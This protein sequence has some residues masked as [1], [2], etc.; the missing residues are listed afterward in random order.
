MRR[1]EIKIATA[2]CLM[3]LSSASARAQILEPTSI[4]LGATSFLDGAPPGPGVYFFQYYQN[5]SAHQF[6]DANGQ[7]VPFPSPNLNISVAI[8]Q[9]V[10]LFDHDL[11]LL[12]AKPALDLLVPT[13]WT[14]LDYGAP[15]PFP[16]SN[17][18]GLSDIT[19]GPALQFD[20]IKNAD[21]RTIFV[22]RIEAQFIVPTGKYSNQRDVNPGDGYFTFDPYWAGTLFL[23][24]KWEVSYRAHYLWN[25]R[26]DD[27][28]ARLNA[29]SALVGEAF[30][31]NFA[32]SYELIEKKLRVGVNG[33]F[34]D[35]TTATEVDGVRLPG[36]ERLLESAPACSGTS[37]KTRISFSTIIS[38]RRSET[39]PK[40]IA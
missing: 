11:P 37:A 25:G 4:N 22:Q 16:Q 29:Q 12:H 19:I 20:P 9:L 24:P 3:L 27:P 23:T 18:M 35:Q 26:L 10:F 36:R 7:T 6:K 31:I 39:L 40:A 1:V 28:P 34:L 21:G 2:L 38:N 33:Y 32:S 5:Y 14:N 15:G 17:G 13:V 30:H 8:S